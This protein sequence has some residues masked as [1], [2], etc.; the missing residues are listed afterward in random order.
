MHEPV[1]QPTQTK[2][3]KSLPTSVEAAEMANTRSQTAYRQ[4]VIRNQ[5]TVEAECQ[6]EAD[7]KY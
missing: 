3:E 5:W 6:R 4:E 1:E 2:T 7:H